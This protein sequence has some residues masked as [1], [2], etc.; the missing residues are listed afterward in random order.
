MKH[1]D[2]IGVVTGYQESAHEASIRLDLGELHP[3]DKIHIAGD[4]VDL[5]QAIET[6]AVDH[7]P[8]DEAVAGQE[9]EIE[10]ELP[11]KAFA[12]VF[13]VRED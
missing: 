2:R 5:E 13:L 4:G 3:G 11:V 9:V 7:D 1:E 10:T 8:V 12:D 6:L